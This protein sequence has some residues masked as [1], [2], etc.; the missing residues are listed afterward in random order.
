[1]AMTERSVWRALL[2]VTA[3][4]LGATAGDHPAAA[5]APAGFNVSGVWQT[6]FGAGQSTLTMTQAGVSVV[7]TFTNPPG[8]QP[9]ALAGRFTGNVLT[10]RWTD[11]TSSGG[12]QLAF[13]PDGRSFTGTWGRALTSTT[14]GGPWTGV[15]Q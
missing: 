10:G 12:F 15:R 4:A 8:I 9:G 13:S 14:S 3:G 5:Q 1:M 6:V 11:A 7:G 2:V